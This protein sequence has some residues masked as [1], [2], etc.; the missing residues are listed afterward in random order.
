MGENPQFYYRGIKTY[1]CHFWCSRTFKPYLIMLINEKMKLNKFEKVIIQRP[2]EIY[3]RGMRL[4]G[5][6]PANMYTGDNLMPPEANKTETLAMA[7]EWA[8]LDEQTAA[9]ETAQQPSE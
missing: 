6:P 7:E 8:M 2:K 9:E 4:K 5:N 3:M 1:H